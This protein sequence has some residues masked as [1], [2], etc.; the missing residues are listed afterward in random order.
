MDLEV[1]YN[2]GWG[3]P[4]PSN[5]GQKKTILSSTFQGVPNKP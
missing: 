5:S 3:L 4:K 1:K 2:G